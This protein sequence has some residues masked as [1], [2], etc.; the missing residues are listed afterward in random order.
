MMTV[1]A[2]VLI[3]YTAFV[4]VLIYGWSSLPPPPGK[5]GEIELFYSVIVPMRN[6]EENILSLCRDFLELDFPKY[7]YEILLI[8]DHSEDATAE[9]VNTFIAQNGLEISI[10]LL[11]LQKGSGKKSAILHGVNSAQGDIIVTT[12]ADCAVSS[13]WLHTISRYYEQDEH[14]QMVFGGVTFQNEDIFFKKLQ[15]VEFASLIGTGAA[16]LRL[17][18]PSMCNGANLSFRKESFDVVGGYSGNDNIASGDD[19]FLMHKFYQRFPGQVF[20]NKSKHGVVVTKAHHYWKDFF[21]Q[22]KRWASKW[23]YYSSF[24]I[25][26]LAIFIFIVNFAFIAAAGL[27]ASDIKAYS[28]LI[29][30]IIAKVT[31]EGIFLGMI[32]NFLG[33]RLSIPLFVFLQFT[34]PFYVII[35]GIAANFGM[36]TW[37]G[38]K[39]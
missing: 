16:S 31:A 23:R 12:D 20:F 8:D 36:Y 25:S 35:C 10:R 4:V 29:F 39:Y 1:L 26:L 34:Y 18:M 37:K 28:F 24:K 22:R 32:L 7:K 3:F 17:R 9:I 19:E 15:T 6:E 5:A 11:P 27:L 2:I 38:R 13:G 33:K 14:T 30:P 21:Q